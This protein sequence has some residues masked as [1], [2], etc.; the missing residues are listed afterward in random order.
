[1]WHHCWTLF[2]RI[3][4]RV[5]KHSK[6]ITPCYL[7]RNLQMN[8]IWL[9]F[10]CNFLF[11][12]R[13][14][15]C[16]WATSLTL[17]AIAIFGFHP[18]Y[19]FQSQNTTSLQYGLYDALSHVIWSIPI[20]YIIFACAHNSGGVINWF[21]SHQF[22]QP[23]S[24]L[25]FA[26]YLVHY[27]VSYLSVASIKTL[28]YFNEITLVQSIIGNTGLSILVAIPATLAFDLP[29]DILDKLILSSGKL[30]L[31]PKTNVPMT[32]TKPKVRFAL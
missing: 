10:E 27:P 4:T 26:I 29:I 32:L 1:M 2:H 31:P 21:L 5:N 19:Q 7:V 14:N 12:Q 6:G 15:L 30:K 18:F 13:W 22:W 3:S 9:F 11:T 20:C 28:P 24:K 17:M 25:S 8:W 23:L 16:A